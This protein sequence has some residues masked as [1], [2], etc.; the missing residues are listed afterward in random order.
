MTTLLTWSVAR[1]SV[2]SA[3]ADIVIR[4]LGARQGVVA[5]AF[6]RIPHAGQL[7]ALPFVSMNI[8]G[9]LNVF[10]KGHVGLIAS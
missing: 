7:R 9:D 1:A 3:G 4:Y 8:H 5:L 10:T 2:V 6:Q